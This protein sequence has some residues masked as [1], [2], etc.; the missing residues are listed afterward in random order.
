[1]ENLLKKPW[2]RVA[3][4]VYGTSTAYGAQKNMAICTYASPVS[5]K[6][7]MY[8]VALYQGTLTLQ[9][10]ESANEL[11]LQILSQPQYYLVKLLG[12]NSG[13]QLDKIKVLKDQISYYRN[14]PFLAQALAIIHL[15]VEA[16]LPS[17]DHKGALCRVVGYKNLNAGKP[18]TTDY[19]RKKNIIRA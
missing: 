4:V 6:P 11:L 2:N 7:K 3:E 15:K 12:K 9:L 18:L 19:L 16:W 17:G 8:I 14:M 5:L 13:H 10:A 1:M